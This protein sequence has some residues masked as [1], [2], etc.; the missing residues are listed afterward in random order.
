MGWV[1][2]VVHAFSTGAWEGFSSHDAASVLRFPAIEAAGDF[3]MPSEASISD[4]L[5]AFRRLS[6][7]L[8]GATR[9]GAYSR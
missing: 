6:W 8:T 3:F 4:S 2:A 5:L 9:G 7:R 1:D